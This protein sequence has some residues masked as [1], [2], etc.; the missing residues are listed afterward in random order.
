[1]R[2][3]DAIKRIGKENWDKFK[4]FMEGQTIGTYP[5]G[6]ANIYECDVENFIN[7]LKGK[8]TFFD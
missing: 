2:E 4:E 5:D 6:S 1:M 3:E 7:K 8:P